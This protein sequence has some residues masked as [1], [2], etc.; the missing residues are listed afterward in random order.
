MPLPLRGMALWPLTSTG[1][2]PQMGVPGW[3]PKNRISE[4][5]FV[6]LPGSQDAGRKG[7]S[8]DARIKS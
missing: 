4:S 6:L 2:T 8:S 5:S 1:L 3:P 7:S